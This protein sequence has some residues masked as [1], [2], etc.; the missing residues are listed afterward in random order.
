MSFWDET[1]KEVRTIQRYLNKDKT[2]DDMW[3]SIGDVL[4]M[5][6]NSFIGTL[7]A[8]EK[9]YERAIIEFWDTIKT[10]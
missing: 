2:D 4:L 3:M 8:T 1:I 5:L 9:H 10:P 7:D 6:E